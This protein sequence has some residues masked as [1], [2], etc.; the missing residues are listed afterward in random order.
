MYLFTLALLAGA[1]GYLL[2]TGP[3]GQRFGEQTQRLR[4]ASSR[5]PGTI[6]R[7]W[8]ALF[9]QADVDTFRAWALGPGVKLL[10]ADLRQ[11]LSGLSAEEAGQFQRSLDEYAGSLGFDL[12]ELIDGGLDH[13][14]RLRQV[15]VE[16][17]VVYSPAY[18]KARKA[19]EQAADEQGE[20][21][22]GGETEIQAAE[23]VPSRRKSNHGGSE[24]VEIPASD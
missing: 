9:R 15:F 24:P 4:S 17:I 11:W 22:D 18:R 12:D 21:R 5:R 19:Q 13:D 6:E 23:K 20:Q 3:Y 1:L 7:R 2:A 16:A 14:P 10:P 8:K